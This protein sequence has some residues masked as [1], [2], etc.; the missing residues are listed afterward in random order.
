MQEVQLRG[1]R[2]RRQCGGCA[3]FLKWKQDKWGGGLCEFLDARTNA[4][5]NA[6]DCK[7]FSKFN[8]KREYNEKRTGRSIMQEIP[9]DICTT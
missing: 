1:I 7:Y 4:Q 9:K 6:K 2:M 3:N 8:S 5:H